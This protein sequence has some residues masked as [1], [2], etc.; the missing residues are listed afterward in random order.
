MSFQ[1]RAHSRH[2]L[3]ALGHAAGQGRWGVLSGMIL[4][5]VLFVAGA[6]AHAGRLAAAGLDFS[7]SPRHP[8]QVMAFYSAR[9]F[10]PE[11]VAAIARACFLTVGLT[12]LRPEVVWLEPARW[13][14]ETMDGRPVRRIARAEWEAV[15]EASRTPLAHRA[16]FGWTQLPERRDLQPGE[17]VGGN[18]TVEPPAKP[19]RLIAVFPTGERGEGPP[20]ELRI[21]NLSCPGP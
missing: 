10:A 13:R 17:P 11:T 4:G 6:G 7:I 8:E 20:I 2:S 1:S 9:G 15:F 14:F 19:F 21:E 3:S 12:N 18:V 5:G 16:T